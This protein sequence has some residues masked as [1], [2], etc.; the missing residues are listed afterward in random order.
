MPSTLFRFAWCY[1]LLAHPSLPPSVPCSTLV[2]CNGAATFVFGP[3]GERAL[4]RVRWFRHQPSDVLTI[5][6]VRV[7]RSQHVCCIQ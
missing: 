5:A 2:C 7:A 3:A 6:L 1:A 4:V